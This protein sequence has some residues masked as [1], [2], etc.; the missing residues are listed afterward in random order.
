MSDLAPGADTCVF[1]LTIDW[2][3]FT[4]PSASAQTVMQR[5]EGDWSRRKGGF[6][7][8][9]VSWVLNHT[10]GVG[11]LGTGALRQP[12]EVHVDLSAGIVS[13]WDLPQVKSLLKWVKAQEGHLTR[14]DC[15]LDDRQPLVPLACVTQAADVGQCISRADR[16]QLI[17]S[18]SL[19]QG[20]ASGE[21]IYFGSP[22]SQTLL[23]VYDKRLE[24]TAKKHPHAEE[25]GI[26]WELEFKQDRAQLCGQALIG[27][28]EPDWKGFLI[29]LLRSYVDFR[30]TTRDAEDEERAR[31]PRLAWY[32]S[33]TK[34]FMNARLSVPQAEP[35]AER[36][37]GW[38]ER[39]VAP[40]LAAL[41]ALP[42]GQTW[43]EGAIL[44]GADRWRQRHRQLVSTG[45]RKKKDSGTPAGTRA[46]LGGPGVS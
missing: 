11:L 3:A 2:I 9:P 17:R 45:K 37:K 30:D 26:R 36:V 1:T 41:C 27:L 28:E 35:D 16:V 29:G 21:T 38:I 14:I 25:Y 19:H 44:E 42:G 23:R 15:A 6:R 12:Q 4:V 31:A 22:Q 7:S 24:L 13:S 20:T 46:H 40:M 5:I 39:S 33:L 18:F 10:L 32:E 43:M 34:G 8:Y